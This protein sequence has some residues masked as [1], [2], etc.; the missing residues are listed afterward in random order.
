MDNLTVVSSCGKYSLVL[1]SALLFR[2]FQESR[3]DSHM[4]TGRRKKFDSVAKHSRNRTVTEGVKFDPS[5][6]SSPGNDHNYYPT[7]HAIK[8]LMQ[9]CT[10]VCPKNSQFA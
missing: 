3:D 9:S 2:S 5:I 4:A 7:S 10:R 1:M 8:N 6:I